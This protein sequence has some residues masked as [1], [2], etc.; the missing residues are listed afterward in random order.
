MYLRNAVKLLQDTRVHLAFVQSRCMI[1]DY[2]STMMRDDLKRVITKEHVKFGITFH[3][4]FGTDSSGSS[5]Q[6]DNDFLR[7]PGS[8]DKQYILW[9]EN[10]FSFFTISFR[11]TYKRQENAFLLYVEAICSMDIVGKAFEWVLSTW[12][13]NDE[14]EH[15][16]RQ[17]TATSKQRGLCVGEWFVMG[18]F[19]TLQGSTNL[20][21]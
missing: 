10:V 20:S 21:K 14:V 2:I 17:V 15:S 6:K 18:S 7:V 1:G 19:Q 8:K 11:K 16:L 4:A 5:D 12:N 9:V 3:S 13:T